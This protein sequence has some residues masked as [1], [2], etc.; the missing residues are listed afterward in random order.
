MELVG[1]AK[2]VPPDVFW[3]TTGETSAPGGSPEVPTTWPFDT[4]LA[5]DTRGIF[6]EVRVCEIRESWQEAHFLSMAKEVKSVG[7]KW[8]ETGSSAFLMR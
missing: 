6:L 1:G 5:E 4:L 3:G 7:N 2:A 8:S